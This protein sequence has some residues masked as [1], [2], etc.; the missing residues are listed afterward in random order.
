MLGRPAT[1]WRT[2]VDGVVLGSKPI[3]SDTGPF[4][5]TRNERHRK[6]IPTD[7]GRR[8]I[9]FSELKL[10]GMLPCFLSLSDLNLWYS[11][12]DGLLH[13]T[14]NAALGEMRVRVTPVKVDGPLPRRCDRV[15]TLGGDTV[16]ER[17]KKAG[18]HHVQFVPFFV[19]LV[20]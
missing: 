17:S 14:G 8:K 13:M 15:V 19:P 11:D 3:F 2:T 18:A 20:I 9:R 1:R 6:D 12:D 4:S 5:S 10:T 16:H 7:K